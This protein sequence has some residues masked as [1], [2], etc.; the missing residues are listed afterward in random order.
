MRQEVNWEVDC[1]RLEFLRRLYPLIG[2][3]QGQLP[4]LLDIFAKRE[5]ECLLSDSISY[6]NRNSSDGIGERFIGFVARTGYKDEPEVDEDG[7][8]LLR[9]TTPVHRAN[10][11]SVAADLFKIYDRFDVNYTDE[12]GL[13]HFHVACQLDCTDVVEKFLELGQDPNCLPLRARVDPPLHLAL[14]HKCPNVTEILLRNGAD[15]NL[16][17]AYGFAPLQIICDTYYNNDATT[18][19]FFEIIDELDQTVRLKVRDKSGNTPLHLALKWNDEELIRML[20][21][22]GVDINFANEEGTTPLHVICEKHSHTKLAEVLEIIADKNQLVQIDAQ[23]NEGNTSLHLALKSGNNKAMELLLRNGSNP[24]VPNA[25]GL[26]PLH[27][28]IDN[29]RINCEMIELFFTI[30]DDIQQTVQINAQDNE[31]NTPLHLSLKSSNDYKATELLL[32]NGANPNVPNAKGLTSLH[33][34]I[35]KEWIDYDMLE[36]L[37]TIN[38]N[39][40]QTVQI[41]AQDNEGNTPL[42]LAILKWRHI[43]AAK[44]LLRRGADPNLANVEGSTALHI[45]C[46]I[47][48]DLDFYG[49]K[50]YDPDV[51]D[52]DDDYD[53]DDGDDDDDDVV[54][55]LFKI[56]DDKHQLVQVDAVDP[57]GRTPLQWAVANHLPDVVDALL[58]HGAN[59]LSFVFPDSSYFGEKIKVKKF[60]PAISNSK[61]RVASRAL[62]V[63][64]C[65][66]KRGYKLN[67]N[68]ALTI[69]KNFDKHMSFGFQ[70]FEEFDY[71]WYDEEKFASKAKKIMMKPDLSLYELIRLRPEE[72]AKKFTCSDYFELMRKDESYFL[73]DT[74]EGDMCSDHLCEIMT[75]RFYRRYALD[76]FLDLIRYQLPIL[77]CEMIIGYLYNQ[78]LWHICLAATGKSS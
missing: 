73:P 17:D 45:I 69:M 31:G 48:Y 71:Y 6:S 5:I 75:K 14:R 67:R 34:M 43:K 37:L 72:A 16:A 60:E 25:K 33:I 70:E 11:R 76:F 12:S 52:Y 44:W 36:L 50:N 66:E 19:M 77:C 10:Q 21:K 55:L 9:R 28:M 30:N 68:D 51:D 24:N 22:K 47:K 7:K 20:L 54:Q 4:N 35:N 42:H 74:C 53:Y 57:L 26:T 2:S 1:E 32:R 27:I 78:D 40:Q 49:A 59:L 63:V 3:W 18:K 61:L 39:I 15:P 46:Q 58:D 65:L 23:D 13:S 64:E 8:A 38:G 41:N 56:N 29:Y 62:T